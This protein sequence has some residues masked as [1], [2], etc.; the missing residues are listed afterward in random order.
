META[1]TI[2]IK[3]QLKLIRAMQKTINENLVKI[4]KQ[5]KK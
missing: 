5:L 1:Q 3:M 4:S 2:K